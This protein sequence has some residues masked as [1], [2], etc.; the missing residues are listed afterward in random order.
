MKSTWQSTHA[1]VLLLVVLVLGFSLDLA[2]KSWAF[3]TVAGT[4]VELEASLLILNPHWTPIPLHEG[5]EVIPSRL[6]D[7]RLV[8]NDGAVFGIGSQQ[9]GLFIFF[10]FIWYT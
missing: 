6:L 10:T 3:Q 1:W 9:R 4:P 5:V 2:S 8:L 7:L